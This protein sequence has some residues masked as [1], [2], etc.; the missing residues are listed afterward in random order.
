MLLSVISGIWEFFL[1]LTTGSLNEDLILF[2]SVGVVA[3]LVLFYMVKTRFAYEG[4][5]VRALEKIN[6]WLYTH[7]QIDQTNLVQFNN[8]IK[9]S[10]KLLRYHWQQ[11]MLYR[12]KE[13]SHYMSVFNCIE[14]P[15]KTSSYTSNIKT[16]T[17][18]SIAMMLVSFL[19]TLISFGT[20]NLTV[21]SIVISLIAPAIIMVLMVL[22][23]ILLRTMQNFTLASLYQNFH[24]FNRYVDKA[25]ATI[26]KYVDFEILFTRKEIR[27][28]IPV[29]NEYLEKRDRQEAEELEKAKENAVEH[30]VYDFEKVGVDGSLILDRAMKE[31]ETF[32]N[33]RQRILSQMNQYEAE[34]DTLKK[35]Y[36]NT[37]KDYQRKLQ[38]S[39]ENIERLRA[40]QEESTNRIEV[41]YIRKQQQD[42]IKKQ[43]QL[44]KDQDSAMLRY[45]QETST[46]KQQLE[47]C[48]VELEEKKKYAQDSMLAEFDTFSTKVY[49]AIVG[50]LTAKH[51]EELEFV[52][53]QKNDA[54]KELEKAQE[55]NQIKDNVLADLRELIHSGEI[56]IPE[57]EQKELYDALQPIVHTIGQQSQQPVEPVQTP[58]EPMQQPVEP[59]NQNPN[60]ETN[61]TP[62]STP[63][64]RAKAQEGVNGSYDA[65]GYNGFNNGTYYDDKGFFHDQNDNIYDPQGNYVS[66]E[67]YA[68]RTGVTSNSAQP[69]VNTANEEPAK[70]QTQQNSS[71]N[72]QEFPY[73]SFVQP[74][75]QEEYPFEPFVQPTQKEYPYEP[76]VSTPQTTPE[77]T[78]T[79]VQTPIGYDQYTGEPIYA[80]QPAPQP[81]EEPAP[82]DDGGEVVF[83]DFDTTAAVQEPVVA[84]VEEPTK[85]PVE[86]EIPAPRKRGRP[87]KNPVDGGGTSASKP[88][89]TGQRG[90]PRKSTTSSSTTKSTGT[91]KRGRPRKS[92]TSSTTT[93]PAGTGKRGRPRKNKDELTAI[94]SQILAESTRLTEQQNELNRQL[95]DTLQQ[96]KAH[97]DNDD[98]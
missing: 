10:P 72:I 34:L 79:P 64:F 6:R 48:K 84:P 9:T 59:I 2:I 47:K 65:Y 15:L 85:E 94:S 89:G 50:D 7:Q 14:K 23:V 46:L 78:F 28:G 95:V 37:S 39:K 62:M 71:S 61:Q 68:R 18:V 25:S 1:K 17:S 88:A 20:T 41:N 54:V 45:E 31:S 70:P 26:P 13:P 77:E 11:F 49:N 40:Q 53:A 27:G 55:I 29:L 83:F 36:D 3:F 42:E 4:R 86:E 67:E 98:E 57:E 33:S 96:L 43:E 21:E 97:Q 32:I 82:F 76:F 93:K 90:R 19:L 80:P 73:G 63:S 58:F 92:T 22:F 30:E 5:L 75:T 8:L 24:L 51:N 66:K 69:N 91:G 81:V 35:N 44:E 56:S 74:D 16:F 60:V 52:M 38:A 87:R 12:E